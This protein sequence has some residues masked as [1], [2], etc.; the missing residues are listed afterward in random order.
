MWDVLFIDADLATMAPGATPYGAI[1]DG[2]LGIEGGRIVYA[3]SVAGLPGKPESLARRV[4]RLNGAWITP[5]LIDCHTHLVFAGERSNEF[6]MRLDGASYEEIAKAGGGIASTVKATR[7]AS[8]DALVEASRPRL[9]AMAKGGVTTVEIKSGYGLDRETEFK[10]LEAATRLGRESGLRV[11]RTFL[12]MHALPPT[13][14]G[15][16]AD[17]VRA[18]C[19]EM[20]PEAARL[21]LVDAVDAFCEGIG[22]TPDEVRRLFDAATT[23]GLPVK[24]HAEQLSDLGGAGLAASYQALSADHLEHV[25]EADIEAMAKNGVVAVLLPGAFYFLRETRKP[26]VGLLRKHGVAMAIASDCNPGTSP[27]VGSSLVMNMACTFFALTPE[28]ALAGMTGNAAAALG[29][30]GETG[31]LEA[32]KAADV[33]IW[34]VSRPA[35]IVYWIGA[36]A[37]ERVFASGRE[38]DL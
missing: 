22:F 33:A 36:A 34:R 3:G 5:G 29:L 6:E 37:P 8:L 14:A 9:L 1:R 24:L 32:G 26:P 10:M 20:L 27:M 17:Y 25:N 12:A 30:A 21:G 18:V 7:D 11:K 2:A 28:E 13:Y 31:T 19:D 4:E 38:L 23:L 35:E 16:R 15:D